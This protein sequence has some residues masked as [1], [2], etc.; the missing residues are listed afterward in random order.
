LQALRARVLRTAFSHGDLHAASWHIVWTAFL[1]EAHRRIAFVLNTRK[2]GVAFPIL[3][4]YTTDAAA[5]V[6]S[7]FLALT[8]GRAYLAYV[9][10]KVIIKRGVADPPRWTITA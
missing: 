1:P 8:T 7:A 4:T 3:W 2:L 6:V 10:L 5:A 9:D